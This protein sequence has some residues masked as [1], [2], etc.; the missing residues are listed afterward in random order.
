[1]TIY[2]C[3]ADHKDVTVNALALNYCS[4]CLLEIWNTCTFTSLE[5][6]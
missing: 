2:L 4:R 5:G 6:S 3:V 1:M